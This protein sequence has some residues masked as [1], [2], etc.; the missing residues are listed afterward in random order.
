MDRLLMGTA[1]GLV[2]SLCIY[3]VAKI[4]REQEI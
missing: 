1:V 2:Y 4:S 3:Y